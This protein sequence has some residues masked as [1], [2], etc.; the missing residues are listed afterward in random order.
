MSEYDDDFER[1]REEY[2]AHLDARRT[3]KGEPSPWPYP[4]ARQA[5]RIF[6]SL[7]ERF[8]L[9]DLARVAR[10]PLRRGTTVAEELERFLAQ[11]VEHGMAIADEEA[12]EAGIEGTYRKTG[13]KPYRTDL[14]RLSPGPN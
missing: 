7:P 13:H 8:L 14:G 10:K 1:R 5:A 11:Y 6:E 4:I 12:A 9:A 2:R 3:P